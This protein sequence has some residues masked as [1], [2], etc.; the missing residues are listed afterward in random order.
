MFDKIYE[1]VRLFLHNTSL[2]LILNGNVHYKLCLLN[3]LVYLTVTLDARMVYE[4]M[5]YG[6][7][8]HEGEKSN[9]FSLNLPIGQIDR[10]KQI[11]DL[12]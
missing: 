2:Q 5:G 4:S 9:G 12:S 10:N 1:R 3:C 8:D 7:V 6:L 11:L